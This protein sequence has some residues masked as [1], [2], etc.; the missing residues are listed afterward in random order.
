LCIRKNDKYIEHL[1]LWVSFRS[2]IHFFR[3]KEGAQGAQETNMTQTFKC[4][5][6]NNSTFVPSRE[7]PFCMECETSVKLLKSFC[8]E[9]G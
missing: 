3:F 2:N 9:C 7:V 8:E 5:V 4:S 6:V 1:S